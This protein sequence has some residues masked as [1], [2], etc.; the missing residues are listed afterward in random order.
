MRRSENYY[1]RGNREQKKTIIKHTQKGE[2]KERFY[3]ENALGGNREEKEKREGQSWKSQNHT[4]TQHQERGTS[5]IGGHRGRRGS[6]DLQGWMGSGGCRKQGFSRRVHAEQRGGRKLTKKK[7]NQGAAA[8]R[9]KRGWTNLGNHVSELQKTP[10]RWWGGPSQRLEG[11]GGRLKKGDLQNVD[12]PNPREGCFK[13]VKNWKR[14][15]T[16]ERR[17]QNPEA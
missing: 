14:R 7:G 9:K 5:F 1:T 12:A 15:R 6:T 8:P 11:V 2:E 3:W 13:G 17:K 10:A 16:K 4:E